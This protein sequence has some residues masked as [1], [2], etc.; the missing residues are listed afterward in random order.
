V[1]VHPEEADDLEF[2]EGNEA[3]LAEHGVSPLD[4]FQVWV[5]DPTYARNKKGLA[6]TYLM[7]GETDGG[8]KLTIAVL[9][10]GSRLR[11]ITGWP[12]TSGELTKW[13]QQRR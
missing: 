3:H 6:G 10:L 12:S 5:N 9:P 4:V 13:G 7:V 1:S 11:P 2:D 8:R